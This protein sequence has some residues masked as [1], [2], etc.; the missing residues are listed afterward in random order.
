MYIW[1]FFLTDN[2]GYNNADDFAFIMSTPS[3]NGINFLFED[4][5]EFPYYDWMPGQ[6]DGN[7]DRIVIGGS[8]QKMDDVDDSEEHGFICEKFIQKHI[9]G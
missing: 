6:P 1:F 2:Q 8:N 9:V 4:T 7:S 5:T 3:P